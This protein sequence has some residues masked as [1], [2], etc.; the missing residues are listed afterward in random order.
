M[1]LGYWILFQNI[2]FVLHNKWLI[3]VHYVECP[4]YNRFI[5]KAK[6]NHTIFQDGSNIVS[7]LLEEITEQLA[8]I[9]ENATHIIEDINRQI[10]KYNY[11]SNGTSKV[12]KPNFKNIISSVGRNEDILSKTRESL[13]TIT[14]M[15]SFILETPY[16]QSHADKKKVA[17]LMQDISS[18]I[19]HTTFLSNKITFLLDAT[20][21]MINI[22]QS[23]IIK[24]VSVAAV[25]FLPPTLVASIYGMNFQHMPEIEWYL[26]YPASLILMVLSGFLPYKY[27]KYKGWL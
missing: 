13:F 4:F 26:G 20:L 7:T 14:R 8:D 21:G 3:I 22:E 15:L 27:F 6:L 16:F 17:M 11:E 5:E 25:V 10:F 2:T 12:K 24:I 18:L 1:R 23:A 19:E 9:L